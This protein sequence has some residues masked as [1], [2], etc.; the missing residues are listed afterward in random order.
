GTNDFH[1]SLFE[2]NRVNKLQARNVFA[3]T[4]PHTV[5]NQFGGSLGG[6]VKRDKLF[7]FGDYQGSRDILGQI[8][9]PTIPTMPMRAGD[10]SGQTTIYDPKTGNPDGTGRTPFAGNQVPS[11][12]ISP[13][14]QQYLSFL[15]P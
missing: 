14:T 2:Y 6:H 3:N 13:I 1:G 7:F 8:A 5:Y 15:P 4:V 12:R 9:T 10:F 11:N